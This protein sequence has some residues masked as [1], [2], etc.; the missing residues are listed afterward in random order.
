MDQVRAKDRD[1][2]PLSGH[3]VALPRRTWRTSGRPRSWSIDTRNNAFSCSR[4]LEDR[5]K[6]P[7]GSP[8]Q[9]Y[10]SIVTQRD[11]VD[12]RSFGL[13]LDAAQPWV[14]ASPPESDVSIARQVCSM[15]SR[16]RT[17]ESSIDLPARPNFFEWGFDYV[18]DDDGCK[19]L[20]NREVQDGHG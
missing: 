11:A 14:I 17:P 20:R 7:A 5:T 16:G 13:S 8:A 9:A 12:K 19:S 3:V 15:L 4:R 1:E 18:A 10:A 6:H 2:L